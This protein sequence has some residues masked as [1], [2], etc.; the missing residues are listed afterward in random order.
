MEM[1][2]LYVNAESFRGS[3]KFPPNLIYRDM[4]SFQLVFF[5]AAVTLITATTNCFSAPSKKPKAPEYHDTL[6]ESVTPTSITVVLD[7]T[8]K[9]YPINQFTEI[10]LKG[11]KTTLAELRPGMM[12]TVVLAMD[13]ITAS[14][15]NAG[16]PPVHVEPEKKKVKV[17]KSFMK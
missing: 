9:I 6:I 8:K 15:V 11:Q 2:P 17:S 5:L 14:R 7:K 16:D 3:W 10:A 1:L 13:G 4:R 12:V